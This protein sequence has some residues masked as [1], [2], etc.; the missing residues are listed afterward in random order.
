MC[1]SYSYIIIYF[2]VAS[3]AYDPERR[4]IDSESKIKT[5]GKVW[6]ILDQLRMED[7]V[8]PMEEIIKV[9]SSEDFGSASKRRDAMNALIQR[10]GR[11]VSPKFSKAVEYTAR[12]SLLIIGKPIQSREIIKKTAPTNLWP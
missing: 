10:L 12:H 1:S 7:C 8:D 5:Q 9:L 4:K 2:Y 3:A 6:V 11:K